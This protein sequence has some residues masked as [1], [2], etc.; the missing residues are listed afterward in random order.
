MALFRV[1]D[2]M[3]APHGGQILRLRLVD[4]DPPTVRA[5]RG[6]TLEARSPDGERRQR[7]RVDGF[8]LFG[9]KPSD[10]RIR[11]TG[12]VDVHVCPLDGETSTPPALKWEVEGPLE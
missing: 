9:G 11:K 1:I 2:A 10:A 6:A 4:G 3:A 12:R 5:L 8:A 7:I